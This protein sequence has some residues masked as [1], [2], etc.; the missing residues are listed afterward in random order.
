MLWLT[1]FNYQMWRNYFLNA[2]FF[3][4]LLPFYIFSPSMKE[5][6]HTKESTFPFRWS[7]LGGVGTTGLTSRVVSL[8][9]GTLY[10]ITL[11]PPW[12]KCLPRYSPWNLESAQQLLVV[13]AICQ[14]RPCQVKWSSIVFFKR[15]FSTGY[16]FTIHPT[17]ENTSRM[18]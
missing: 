12:L 7:P 2:F 4:P 9:P 10:R 5:N 13:L 11:F 15:R 17:H 3:C 18:N 8:S 1:C 14:Y 16:I 6:I